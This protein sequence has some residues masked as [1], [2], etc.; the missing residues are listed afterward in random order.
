LVALGSYRLMTI[1]ACERL[2]QGHQMLLFHTELANSEWI[3][4]HYPKSKSAP[5][6]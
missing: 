6:F 4:W 1:G 3:V 2:K 5:K